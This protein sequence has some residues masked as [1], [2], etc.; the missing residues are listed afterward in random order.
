M[1]SSFDLNCPLLS[2]LSHRQAPLVIRF[3]K[4]KI[5][6]SFPGVDA[7]DREIANHSNTLIL[8]HVRVG[9]LQE[10]KTTIAEYPGISYQ[11]HG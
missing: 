11:H 10:S 5:D 7:L 8:I 2:Y 3:I 1:P 6:K 4:H 9:C